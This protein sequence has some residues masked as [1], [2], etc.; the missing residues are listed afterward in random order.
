MELNQLPEHVREWVAADRRQDLTLMQAQL[1]D[2]VVL[3]S[4]LTDAFTFTGP[5]EVMAVFEAAFELLA[6][7]E[8]ANVTGAGTDWA[9]HGTN[10]IGGDNLEEIQWLQLGADGRIARI[11]LF[12][13]PAPAAITLLSRIGPGLKAR[14][15]MGAAAATASGAAK[16]L[17][18]ALRLTEGRVM[19]RLRKREPRGVTAP[20]G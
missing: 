10:T 3:I 2:D 20:L 9:I 19:P 7:I 17:A 1:S 12:I 6:D 16:P 14:G 11:T 4:P 5:G 15:L 13:R 8:I 18:A